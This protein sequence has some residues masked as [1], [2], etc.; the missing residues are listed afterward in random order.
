MTNRAKPALY[1]TLVPV[2]NDDVGYRVMA[3]TS[4]HRHQVY[5]RYEYEVSPT[6][7]TKA[8]CHGQFESAALAAAALSRVGRIIRS[9]SSRIATLDA[10]IRELLRSQTEEIEHATRGNDRR[11][12]ETHSSSSQSINGATGYCD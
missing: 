7:R 5:G 1:Y 11:E 9:H 4:E 3:V 8:A 12:S 6:N 2:G 10:Q